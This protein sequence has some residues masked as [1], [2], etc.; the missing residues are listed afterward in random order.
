M[1]NKPVD[2]VVA[3]LV[4]ELV[5]IIDG[6]NKITNDLIELLGS[7]TGKKPDRP[8]VELQPDMLNQVARRMLCTLAH[9]TTMPVVFAALKAATAP[10]SV[11]D[12][13][14]AIQAV[15]DRQA[16]VTP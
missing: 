1:S 7:I 10:S 14:E 2:I 12:I 6:N 11:D 9:E 15:R 13:K 16:K 3:T 4:H 8:R 5:A